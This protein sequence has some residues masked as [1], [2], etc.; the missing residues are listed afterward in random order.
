MHRASDPQAERN[1]V[2]TMQWLL[3]PEGPHGAHAGPIG[4]AQAESARML[5]TNSR[6]AAYLDARLFGQALAAQFRRMEAASA[7][8]RRFLLGIGGLWLGVELCVQPTRHGRVYRAHVCDALDLGAAGTRS[9]SVRDLEQLGGW[10]LQRWLPSALVRDSFART[11]RPAIGILWEWPAAN[12]RPLKSMEGSGE[13]THFTDAAAAHPCVASLTLEAGDVEAATRSLDL[14]LDKIAQQPTLARSSRIDGPAYLVRD[15]FW[16]AM[17]AGR[18]AAAEAYMHRILDLPADRV[19]SSTKVALLRGNVF[20]IG[21]VRVVAGGIGIGL[22]S[23]SWQL[24]AIFARIIASTQVLEPHDKMALL[25]AHDEEDGTGQPSG[26]PVL[27]AVAAHAGAGD[28][29]V[30][31]SMRYDAIYHY[32]AEIVKTRG[33]GPHDQRA[34]CA[35]R[36]GGRTAAREALET[37][38]PF[39]AAAMVCAVLENSGS[40]EQA[41]DL[42][43]ATGVEIDEVL[44]ALAAPP[45]RATPDAPGWTAKI[46]AAQRSVLPGITGA[47]APE[48][49]EQEPCADAVPSRPGGRVASHHAAEAG[50]AVRVHAPA[51]MPPLP[52][53][54][55]EVRNWVRHTDFFNPDLARET[56]VHETRGASLFVP[57]ADRLPHIRIDEDRIVWVT[58]AGTDPL[59]LASGRQVFAAHVC[60]ALQECDELGVQQLLRYLSVHA[61]TTDAFHAGPLHDAPRRAPGSGPRA[62]AEMTT[63]ASVR[64]P[65]VAA[66][67]LRGSPP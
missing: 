6:P 51:V 58:P 57:R 63:G 22:R 1:L 27:Y 25:L 62:V 32:L 36:H 31:A 59:E 12:G 17:K 61:E 44:E 46:L 43:S 30:A 21:G 39:F 67:R 4:A 33:L 3:R 66:P 7:G 52:P 19:A 49:H 55:A 5:A 8:S 2:G 53:S 26:R 15:G 60:C 37:A 41:L 64:T 48:W 18:T 28:D 47:P 23:G 20:D 65:A 45:V 13:R 10:S 56:L 11:P 38:H 35:S 50:R 16:R 14:T 42:L 24:A 40:T 34:I 54:I 9:A 29:P